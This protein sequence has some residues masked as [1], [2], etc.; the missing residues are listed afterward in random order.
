[1]HSST[2]VEPYVFVRSSGLTGFTHLVRS[3]GRLLSPEQ[4]ECLTASFW[5][6]HGRAVEKVCA[7]TSANDKFEDVPCASDGKETRENGRAS[8]SSQRRRESTGGSNATLA[9]HAPLGE[10]Q[11]NEGRVPG[12]R[13]RT[14]GGRGRKPR[15]GRGEPGNW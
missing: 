8:D 1:M 2:A 12:R 14:S 15:A 9:G 3:R 4:W 11:T 5:E 7:E 6:V 10:A 13:R